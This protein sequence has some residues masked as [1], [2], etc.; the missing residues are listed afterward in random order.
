MSSTL[1]VS[2]S[3]V[4]QSCAQDSVAPGVFP[5]AG[6]YAFLLNC[7]GQPVVRAGKEYGPVPFNHGY[8]E[9]VD[10][11][12]GEYLVLDMLNPFGVGGVTFQ[13][14]FVAFG[15]VEVCGCCETVCTKIYQTGW[16]HCF[17]T[18]VL[19]AEILGRVGILD[20]GLVQRIAEPLM[21][22]IKLGTPVREETV[23]V[24][25]IGRIFGQFTATATTKN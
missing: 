20:A 3:A 4:G 9:F 2:L 17:T 6:H 10:V 21:E 7:N 13:S 15:I 5:G 14:N 25:N 19:A 18:T 11:P 24:D 1:R 12:R 23:L 22:A 16:H 8:A